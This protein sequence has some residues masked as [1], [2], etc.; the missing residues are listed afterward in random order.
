[1]PNPL[2]ASL[3]QA[4]MAAPITPAHPVLQPL[5]IEQKPAPSGGALNLTDEAEPSALPDVRRAL[6]KR[7]ADVICIPASQ[8][9][10]QERYMAGDV[11]V[12][13][14]RDADVTMRESVAKRLVM[15]NEAPRTILLILAKDE[16][17]VARHILEKSKSLT[18]SDLIHIARQ[19][20]M[21]HR[22]MMALRRHLSD[23]V[24]DV[25]AEYLEEDVINTLLKNKGANFS[26]KTIQ[27]IMT[28]SRNRPDYV[29]LL[30]KRDETR[31]FHGL[32]MFWWADQAARKVILHRFAV[33]RTVLQES[34]FDLY[35]VA[36]AQGWNDAAVRKALQFIERRQRNRAAIARSDF[37]SLESAVELAAENGMTREMAE[38]ISHM[39]GIKPATGAQ[40]MSDETGEALA[41]LCKAPGLKR[42]YLTLM[43]RAL[44]RDTGTEETPS[45]EL[46]AIIATYDSISTDK[47]QTVLRYWNWSLTSALNAEVLQYIKRGVVPNESEHGAAAVTAALVFGHKRG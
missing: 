42:R 22:K 39:S 28:V 10:P 44:R 21:K 38:E 37:E 4:S 9:T 35:P 31:P 40:I 47:A 36:A 34:C 17:C 1:M 33:T 32:T 24:V 18:D 29:N 26:E 27:R 14:L 12:E 2:P 3:P 19:V 46:A 6:V 23:A 43:W 11:L 45:A 8:L 15:L 7:L 41:I 16:Y 25:L 13:L 30:I 5:P 20:S